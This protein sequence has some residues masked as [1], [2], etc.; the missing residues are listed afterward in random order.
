MNPYSEIQNRLCLTQPLPYTPDW[1]AAPDFIS[2]IVDYALQ[3]KPGVILECSSGLTTLALARCCQINQRGRVISLENGEEY[4][5]QTRL[6]LQQFALQD[7]A[8]VIDAP[9]QKVTLGRD[10][11]W[12][13]L[14]SLPDVS[15]DMLVIDG[16]PGFI[17]KNSRY[18]SLPLLFDR[19]ADHCSVFL[20]DAARD[21]EKAL[22]AQ[23]QNEF[24]GVEHEYLDFERGCSVLEINK[25][26]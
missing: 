25:G 1:S 21:D 12:Y 14:E 7:Y 16:P 13:S 15:I 2:L 23:W 19:L 22:V 10:Y 3:A 11:D 4:A 20:D 17:Q 5:E 18:P 9:L 6:Q 26:Y 24:S 8:Q